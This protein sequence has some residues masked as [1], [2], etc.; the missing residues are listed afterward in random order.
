MSLHPAFPPT[1]R[2][3]KIVFTSF[4]EAAGDHSLTVFF[5]AGEGLLPRRR[6]QP[7]ET[8]GAGKK[9]FYSLAQE[10]ASMPQVEAPI[11]R[12]DKTDHQAGERL[13]A[14]SCAAI[15]GPWESTLLCG[16]GALCGGGAC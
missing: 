13:E 9:K 14:A 2:N 7:S 11:S 3:H 16:S 5:R 4:F 6:A 8:G 12:H 1:L 15:S 10:A